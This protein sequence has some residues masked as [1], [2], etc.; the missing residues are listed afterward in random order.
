MASHSSQ[1][2]KNAHKALDDM[3]YEIA[4]ELGI[5]VSGQHGNEDYWGHVT[6]REAGSVGGAITQRLVAYAQQVL[7]NETPQS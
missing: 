3:K 2:V 1:L 4:S 5:Q 7:A 6:T